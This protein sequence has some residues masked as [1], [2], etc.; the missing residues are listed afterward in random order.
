MNKMKQKISA[1]IRE[2]GFDA[3]KI[4]AATGLSL[5]VVQSAMAVGVDYTALV[6]AADFGGLGLAIVG[7][8][9]ALIGASLLVAGGYAIWGA[10]KKGRS[11]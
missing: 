8:I 2:H 6:G 4:A 1:A 7:V 10:V 11:V 3:G 5:G 9:V